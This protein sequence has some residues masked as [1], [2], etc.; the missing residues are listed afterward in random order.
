MPFHVY[1]FLCG[2]NNVK[3]VVLVIVPYF[4]GITLTF[5]Q[6]LAKHKAYK[7]YSFLEENSKYN[8]FFTFSSIREIFMPPFTGPYVFRLNGEVYYLNTP[9]SETKNPRYGGDL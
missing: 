6:S 3:I 2:T 9:L 4:Q 7:I 1:R 5:E 8:N